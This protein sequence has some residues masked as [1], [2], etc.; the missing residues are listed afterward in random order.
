MLHT[1]CHNAMLPHP[2]GSPH[3]SDDVFCEDRR[4]AGRHG[5]GSRSDRKR[6]SFP[7]SRFHWALRRSELQCASGLSNEWIDAGLTGVER[8]LAL[9]S[10]A[11]A[12]GTRL[13]A[14]KPLE[15]IDHAQTLPNPRS[16]RRSEI[17]RCA[18]DDPGG[19]TAQIGS[20]RVS[21][22]R[23]GLEPTEPVMNEPD[24]A[25]FVME[26]LSRS[27]ERVRALRGSRA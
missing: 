11:A 5:A 3:R 6:G 20:S 19:V 2:P 21:G 4:R 9:H 27:R 23:N 22:A 7:R 18:R 25:W 12:N 15:R 1:G 10:R 16:T 14:A 17:P 24:L 26:A 13:S 8:S